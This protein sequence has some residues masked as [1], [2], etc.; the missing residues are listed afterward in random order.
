V[1]GAK[2]LGYSFVCITDHSQSLKVANG[3]SVDR[4][5]KKIKKIEELNQKDPGFK[6]YCGTECDIKADGTMDYPD[7]ILKKFDVVYTG[8]HIAF[9]M[10]RKTATKRIIRAMENEYVHAIAH[11]TCRMIGRREPFDLDIEEIMDVAKKTDTFLEINA[12]PDRLDLKDSHV[13]LAKERGV[14]IILGSDTHFVVN[15]PFMRFGIATARRGWLEKKD[16]LNTYSQNDIEK[17]LGVK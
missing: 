14:K 15:L 16:I 7:S 6:I 1:K 10:D 2:N 11:P 9:K 13:K 12:F 4:V 5:D 8:I 17:I 3:L